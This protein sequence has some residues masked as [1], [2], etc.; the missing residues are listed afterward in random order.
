MKLFDLIK[1]HKWLSIELT[2]LNLYSDEEK[3]I[4]GYREVFEKL[5]M[6]PPVDN[7]MLIVL[8]T[9]VDNFDPLEP[10]TYVDVSARKTTEEMDSMEN[11]YAIEFEKWEKWLGMEI[12]D[13]TLENF[14]ELEIIAHCLFEMTF[15]G[16]EEEEIQEQFKEIEKSAED[17]KNL[18]EEER[19]EQTIS[20]EELMKK[21]DDD[22]TKTEEE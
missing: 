10:F 15:C 22:E 11:N 18:T 13:E 19:A 6:I 16:F 5:Q 4:D 20:L 8:K 7:E 17:F 9:V 12:A 2:F 14:N 1:S 21:L 3:S